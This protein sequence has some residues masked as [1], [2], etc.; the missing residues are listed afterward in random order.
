MPLHCNLC[1]QETHG[2]SLFLS[3]D[4][5]RLAF[6]N[7]AVQLAALVTE[8]TEVLVFSKAKGH[9][10]DQV[11]SDQLVVSAVMKHFLWSGSNRSVL[12]VCIRLLVVIGFAFVI[13]DT[14]TFYCRTSAQ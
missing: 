13:S 2:N 7:H 10:S 1:A 3:P 9:A 11:Q 4:V 12:V 14:C 5:D 6:L 8:L